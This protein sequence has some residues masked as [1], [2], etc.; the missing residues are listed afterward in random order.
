MVTDAGDIGL[1]AISTDWLLGVAVVVA[2]PF[3]V[4]PVVGLIT[5]AAPMPKSIGPPGP[6][7]GVSYNSVNAPG[8][9]VDQDPILELSA[10]PENIITA[11]LTV[12]VVE[13]LATKLL[14]V[15]LFQVPGSTSKGPLLAFPPASKPLVVVTPENA[16]I[17]PSASFS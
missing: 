10:R 12:A 6:S 16:T 17:Y 15:K 1:R 4:L 2:V 11:A 3:P 5:Q 13:G 8:V 14:L 9:V 7:S